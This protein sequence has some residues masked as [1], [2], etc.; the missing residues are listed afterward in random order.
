M[1]YDEISDGLTICAE[2]TLKVPI[3]N[4]ADDKFYDTFP[5]KPGIFHEN[6]LQAGDP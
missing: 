6:R 2:L 3:T 4:A 1:A 5:F